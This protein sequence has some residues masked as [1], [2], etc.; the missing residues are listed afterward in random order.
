MCGRLAQLVRAPALQAGG[1]RFEPATAH[2]KNHSAPHSK[3]LLTDLQHFQA[4]MRAPGAWNRVD[5]IAAWAQHFQC[6]GERVGLRILTVLCGLIF[7]NDN[8]IH[9]SDTW[10]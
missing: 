9:R 8:Y 2:H 7:K 4:A 10:N 1:P 6:T 3:L 5:E